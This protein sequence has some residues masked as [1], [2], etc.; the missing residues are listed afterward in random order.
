M[1]ILFI[2]TNLVQVLEAC[3]VGFPYD[4]VNSSRILIVAVMLPLTLLTFVRNL[5]LLSPLS[6]IANMC[7]AFGLITIVYYCFAHLNLPKKD[8]FAGPIGE[9]PL[10]A[11][12]LQW[13]LFFGTALYSFE[14]IG[15]VC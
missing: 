8:K 5:D 4:D 3:G 2:A 1:Y 10:I 13:P 6:G 14:A 9:L 11:P 15:V 7:M 12:V